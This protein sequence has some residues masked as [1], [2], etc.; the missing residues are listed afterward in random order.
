MQSK[1]HTKG[2]QARHV[3]VCVRVCGCV[4]VCVSECVCRVCMSVCVLCVC[5]RNTYSQDSSQDQS[6]ISQAK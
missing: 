5:D 3:C 1:V 4:C 6:Y 2:K